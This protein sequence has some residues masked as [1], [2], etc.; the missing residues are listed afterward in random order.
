[1]DGCAECISMLLLM[2]LGYGRKG[3]GAFH[4]HTTFW[5]SFSELYKH[6]ATVMPFRGNAVFFWGENS[7]LF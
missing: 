7:L 5:L 1:M 2:S 3:H 6:R 4:Q